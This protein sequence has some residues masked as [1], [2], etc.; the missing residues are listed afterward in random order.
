LGCEEGLASFG[1]LP[2]GSGLC[3]WWLVG[4]VDLGLAFCAGVD[5]DLF[6][7]GVDVGGAAEL[8]GVGDADAL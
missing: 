7:C 1:D 2:Q 8:A 4:Q 5:D 3:A 6:A